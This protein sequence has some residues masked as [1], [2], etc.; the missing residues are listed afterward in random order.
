[1]RGWRREWDGD[2][3]LHG[4][5]KFQDNFSPGEYAV[6]QKLLFPSLPIQS[7]LCS[8]VGWLLRCWARA[9]GV[10][11]EELAELLLQTF[12]LRQVRQR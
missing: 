1:M 5:W 2:V 7:S 3:W 6:S 10:E 4:H 12:V 9:G 8:S 11:L